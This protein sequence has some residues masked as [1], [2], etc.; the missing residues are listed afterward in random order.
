[1]RKLTI[2][3]AVVI[4]CAI[5]LGNAASLLYD[6]GFYLAEYE[7]NGVYEHIDK[8]RAERMTDQLFSYLDTDGSLSDDFSQRERQHLA[9][10]KGLII[11]GWVVYY[12]LLIISAILI[13]VLLYRKRSISEL[14]LL[15][16]WTA[17]IIVVFSVLSF[18]L[19]G[20]FSRAFIW[21]HKIFFSNDLWILDPR[22][23]KLIVLLPEQF[24]VDFV[25]HVYLQ[26]LAIAFILLVFGLMLWLT[27]RYK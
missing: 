26:S 10:V 6:K 22:V 2:V 1:M 17:G 15:F 13:S 21:F 4:T 19:Q 24:F 20:L 27:A 5:F 3:A 25:T 11:K 14:G 23:D 8:A 12:C 18:L 16:F 7:K 9:D